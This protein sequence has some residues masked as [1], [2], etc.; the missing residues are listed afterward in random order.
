MTVV[1]DYMVRLVIFVCSRPYVRDLVAAGV[2]IVPFSLFVSSK[3]TGGGRRRKVHRELPFATWIKCVT[4]KLEDLD[5]AQK[6][7]TPGPASSLM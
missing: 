2:Y 1:N 7:K 5:V 3:A 6:V 4:Q